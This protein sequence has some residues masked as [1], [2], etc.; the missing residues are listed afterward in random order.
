MSEVAIDKIA[1]AVQCDAV[2]NGSVRQLGDLMHDPV[3]ADFIHDA[4]APAPPGIAFF[5]YDHT[6]GSEHASTENFH[7]LNGNHCC[8]ICSLFLLR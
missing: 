3:R 7:L 2:G 8:H 5:I 6:F 1:L 4:I